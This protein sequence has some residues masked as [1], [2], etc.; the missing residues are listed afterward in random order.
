MSGLLFPS[1]SASSA[2][3]VVRQRAQQIDLLTY[4]F[5]VCEMQLKKTHQQARTV[6]LNSACSLRL[7]IIPG[8]WKRRS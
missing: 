4:L 8:Q 3:I 7:G 5:R 6:H 2:F 1:T